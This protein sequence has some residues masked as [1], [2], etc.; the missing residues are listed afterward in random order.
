MR[1]VDQIGLMRP[2]KAPIGKKAF[3]FFYV[4]RNNNRLAAGCVKSGVAVV[5]FAIKNFSD[6]DKMNAI[7]GVQNDSVAVGHFFSKLAFGKS[8]AETDLN[9]IEAD[10]NPLFF[11]TFVVVDLQIFEQRNQ[12]FLLPD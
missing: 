3:T 11:L 2:D 4:F 6:I 10:L 9:T 8:F 12:F 7:I 5:A 1:E